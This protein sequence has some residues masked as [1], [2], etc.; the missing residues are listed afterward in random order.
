MALKLSMECQPKVHVCT[1][2][3][4]SH[5][6]AVHTQLFSQISNVFPPN[7][8]SVVCWCTL[9]TIYNSYAS[10]WVW[11]V[12]ILAISKMDWRSNHSKWMFCSHAYCPSVLP[13]I[14]FMQCMWLQLVETVVWLLFHQAIQITALCDMLPGHPI[15]YWSW[16]VSSVTADYATRAP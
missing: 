10:P 12:E 16:P 6:W 8:S 2:R 15:S 13:T 3:L 11:S 7:L 9:L 4:Q 1:V 5:Y 14:L